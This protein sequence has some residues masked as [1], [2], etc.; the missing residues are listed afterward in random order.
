MSD[1]DYSLVALHEACDD[2][3]I[4]EVCA[5]ANTSKE[6]CGR[7]RPATRHLSGF[8]WGP[9]TQVD[10]QGVY[11]RAGGIAELMVHSAMPVAPSRVCV[12]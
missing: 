12:C 3:D 1:H 6:Y 11:W 8:S 7:V 4:D 9:P 2:V 10:V 5:D